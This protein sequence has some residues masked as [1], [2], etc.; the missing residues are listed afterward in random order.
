LNSVACKWSL[1]DG[2]AALKVAGVA[3][4]F[5]QAECVI[6]N[7]DV[8]LDGGKTWTAA[9]LTSPQKEFCWSFWEATLPA[10]AVGKKLLVRATDTRGEAQPREFPYNYKGYQYNAWHQVTLDV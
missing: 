9:R 2:K 5:G 7:V 10:N 6:R 3:L 4:P 1:D 8:S